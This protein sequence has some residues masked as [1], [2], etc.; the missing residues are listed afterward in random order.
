MKLDVAVAISLDG[1]LTRHGEADI[2]A[3]V[4]QEDQQH[5]QTLLKDYPV[6]VMGT[7]VYE[8][9]RSQGIKMEGQGL[10][11]ILT[12]HPETYAAEVVPGKL[13]FYTMT[14]AELVADLESKGFESG[15][16]VGGGQ[17]ITDF[18][19]AGAVDKL[20]ITLEPFLFGTGKALIPE[21]IDIDLTL[22]EQKTL[23]ARGTQLLTYQVAC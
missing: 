22:I 8:M 4:S 3:W 13:E 19:K 16:I 9:I 6:R 23:N 5:F 11:I 15:L 17:M 21:A 1:K 14:P 10:R 2:H 20:Y 12:H 7:T 18:L